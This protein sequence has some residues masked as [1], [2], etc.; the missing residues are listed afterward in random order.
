MR[1]CSSEVTPQKYTS[2][3]ATNTLYLYS[4]PHNLNLVKDY[5]TSRV[6]KQTWVFKHLSQPFIS[7]D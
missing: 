4:F 3:V 2:S 5:F 7:L 1:L 6:E